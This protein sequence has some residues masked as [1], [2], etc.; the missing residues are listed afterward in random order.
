MTTKWF[1]LGF[2]PVIPLSSMR[3]HYLGTTGVPFF[4]RTSTFEVV[5]ELP[6]DWLQA[7]KIWVYAFFIV[8]LTAGLMTS[9]KP[10]AVKILGI[11][12]GILLPHALRWFAKKNAG[13]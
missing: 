7:M 3:A 11:T 6:V 2:F 9:N 10:P 12:A 1:V 4:G 5:E 8:A 13:S